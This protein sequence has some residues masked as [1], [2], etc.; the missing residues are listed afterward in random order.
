MDLNKTPVEPLVYWAVNWTFAYKPC[1]IACDFLDRTQ[2]RL[3]LCPIAHTLSNYLKV[4]DGQ[5]YG[6]PS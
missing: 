4:F 3:P 1:S 6:M 2:T 5:Q